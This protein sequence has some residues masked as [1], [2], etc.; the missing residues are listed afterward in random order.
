MDAG[1]RVWPREMP[2]RLLIP[3]LL[4]LS[5]ISA[6]VGCGPQDPGFM[7]DDTWVADGSGF[8]SLGEGRALTY[9]EGFTKIGLRWDT[10]EPG[11]G[12]A[13]WVR[14]GEGGDLWSGW[15]PVTE[16]WSEGRVH[17]GEV[18]LE[19]EVRAFQVRVQDPSAVSFLAAEPV[20]PGAEGPD[21]GSL[22]PDGLEV[23]SSGDLGTM[24][25][26]LAPGNVANG[27]ES[28][29]A[30]ATRC[31]SRHTP[32][33]ATIHHTVTPTNDTVSPEVRLRGIQHYHMDTR[34]WCDIGYHF[35]VSRDGR[36]WQGRDER[37]V[38]AHVAGHNTGNA[39]ISFMGTY[40]RDAATED[41]LRAAGR[42]VAWLHQTYGVSLDLYGHRDL[43][44]TECPGDMLYSQIPDIEAY[45]RG[46]DPGEGG[47]GVDPPAEVGTYRG[48]VYEAPDS[49][50]RI[51][52][53]RVWV[54][55]LGVDA[56]SAGNG[57]FSFDLPAGVY[58]V[59]ASAEGYLEGSS[60]REV[61]AGEVVWGSIGLV[62]E[63]EPPPED[64]E[65]PVVTI[66]SPRNG[67]VVHEPE[68][69]VEGTV[70]D[71]VVAEVVVAGARVAVSGGRFRSTV[72]LREGANLVV[73]TATDQAGNQ[74]AATVS[75]SYVPWPEEEPDA[76]L[77][78]ED[79]SDAGT[80]EDPGEGEGEGEGEG[81]VEPGPVS[82]TVE[83]LQPSEGAVITGTETWVMGQVDGDQVVAV[84]VNREPAALEDGWRFQARVSLEPG[85]N[86]IV[87]QAVTAAGGVGVAVR[88][89]T[90]VSDPMAEAG[91]E[92]QP[93]GGGAREPE[94]PAGSGSGGEVEIGGGPS[95]AVARV[96][97]SGAWL[98][99]A[100]L[101]LHS[102]QGG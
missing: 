82:P 68:V 100:L 87:V 91:P 1:P 60:T 99:K 38:G 24:I 64:D 40:S 80:P 42:L 53:A 95:C 85:A 37:L 72:H 33:I 86:T 66:T 75:V 73:V 63:E 92:E 25:L 89:V 2:M 83:I 98:A 31:S 84:T 88:H 19:G 43:G 97:L 12:L 77:P 41:Q 7:D 36:V 67:A 3:T 93:G 17:N 49:D 20:L 48:V 59:H 79:E 6:L 8:S 30:R 58:T 45:A 90:C 78:P 35:L 56:V 52:G 50:R 76:G 96:P 69:V 10:V 18:V 11:Q 22:D 57:A 5:L 28:W 44:Q 54:E 27:R 55:G 39:G 101:F 23:G 74:G 21:P 29:G 32:R 46:E 16:T 4:S 65:P 15:L 47:G 14:V 34:G 26:P 70:D 51:P 71:P 94:P 61:V 9:D 81:G 62:R 13:L 102:R